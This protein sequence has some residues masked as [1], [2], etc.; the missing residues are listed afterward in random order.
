M[1]SS[2]AKVLEFSQ[3]HQLDHDFLF[4]VNDCVPADQY[5]VET[6]NADTSVRD[7]LSVMRGTGYSQLPVKVGR[8]VV[9]V[10]SYQSFAHEVIDA[11]SVDLVVLRASDCMQD[12]RFVRAS[13][14]VNDVLDVIIRDNAVLVGEPENLLAIV[15]AA[16]VL[17]KMNELA[18]H[19]ISLATTERS[20]RYLMTAGITTADF[21]LCLERSKRFRKDKTLLP[22]EEMSYNDY[23]LIL[24]DATNFPMFQPNFGGTI[25]R[26]QVRLEDLQ[27]IRNTLFHFKRDL[28]LHQKKLLDEH[29][30]WLSRR[31]ALRAKMI[32][33]T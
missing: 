22:I 13:E 5:D 9:G 25:E 7:A 27:Q 6:I 14:D 15:T 31:I 17:R 24:C 11:S 20:I 26:L 32:E 8:S 29:R 16:D 23:E 12:L 2:S 19:F 1:S 3:Q 30:L 4:R 21:D 28:D 33:S 18:S 10:F